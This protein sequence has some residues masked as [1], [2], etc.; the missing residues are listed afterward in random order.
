M[1]YPNNKR[2]ILAILLAICFISHSSVTAYYSGGKGGKGG[3]GGYTGRVR[4]L[5]TPKGSKQSK[6]AAVTF[7]SVH[8]A[9][10]LL[11]NS[12]FSIAGSG[13]VVVSAADNTVI[14]STHFS[15]IVTSLKDPLVAICDL[16]GCLDTS[17]SDDCIL[18]KARF[19]IPDIFGGVPRCPPDLS[20]IISGGTG[21]YSGATGTFTSSSECDLPSK[22]STD[23]TM[24]YLYE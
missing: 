20:G 10:H 12:G 1:I 9:K 4:R 15:C 3:K 7:T 2:V 23:T 14:G 13:K 11:W 19:E 24:V 17:S 21:M 6:S 16:V 5:S 8:D 18:L 22:T